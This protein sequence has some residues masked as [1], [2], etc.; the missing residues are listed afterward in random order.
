MRTNVLAALFASG[1]AFATPVAAATIITG[2]D[3]PTVGLSSS[4]FVGMADETITG[5]R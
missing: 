1:L 2:A 5:S 4:D 3:G